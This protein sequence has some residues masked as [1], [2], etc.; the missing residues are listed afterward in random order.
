M[1]PAA[2]TGGLTSAHQPAHSPSSRR[3]GLDTGCELRRGSGPSITELVTSSSGPR[4]HP[5]VSFH[6]AAL[7]MA[8]CSRALPHFFPVLPPR[9]M[10]PTFLRGAEGRGRPPPCTPCWPFPVLRWPRHPDSEL[11]HS[12]LVPA[13]SSREGGTAGALRAMWWT[14][15]A[16]LLLHSR[17]CGTRGTGGCICGLWLRC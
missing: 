3:A 8:L 14:G 1:T 16:L 7:M 9:G 12:R 6:A 11:P 2:T 4:A 5:C 17:T 13:V 15:R 10:R